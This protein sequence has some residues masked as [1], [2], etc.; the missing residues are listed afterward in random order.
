MKKDIQVETTIEWDEV[1]SSGNKSISFLLG[2][3]HNLLKE[4]KKY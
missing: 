4:G 3:D 2:Q 1:Y